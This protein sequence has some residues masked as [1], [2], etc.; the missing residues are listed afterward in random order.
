M[1]E[2]IIGEDLSDQDIDDLDDLVESIVD[3]T[4]FATRATWGALTGA[5]ALAVIQ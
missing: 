4:G 1:I 3:M 5:V 2:D